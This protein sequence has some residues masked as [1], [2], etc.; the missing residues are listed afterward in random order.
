MD[1]KAEALAR[2]KKAIASLQRQMTERTLKLAAEVEVLMKHLTPSEARQFLQ[3]ACGLSVSD[4]SAYCKFSTT[5]K[6]SEEALRNARVQFSVVKALV[7]ADAETR[8][9]ALWKI[10]A[11]ARVDVRDVTAIKK[12][13]RDAKLP[14]EQVLAQFRMRRM[15]AAARRRASNSVAALDHRIAAFIRHVEG[16]RSQTARL[17]REEE[18]ATF[19]K[20]R[21]EARNLVP[22]FES[23]FGS[24]HRSVPELLNPS[25]DPEERR[26][27]FV[28]HAL[29]KFAAGK[30][31]RRGGYMLDRSRA[32]IRTT[33]I[34]E[35][36]RATT[37]APRSRTIRPWL[38]NQGQLSGVPERRLKFVELCAGAGGMALGLEAAGFDPIALI[39]MD[40]NAAATLRLNRP[41][42]NVIQQDLRT[43][44]FKPFRNPR[45]DLLVG[46][47]PCQPY[48]ED[49]KGLGK[50]DPR[51]LLLEGA[52][53][54]AELKPWSF[55]F[56]NVSGLLHA[57]HA[58]HLGRF[59]HTLRKSG[60][61]VDI[62]RM[63]TEDYGL[64]Q[65]RERLLIVGM[66]AESM[67]AFRM[68]PRFPHWRTNLG[69]AIGDLLAV[70]GWGGA[71]EWIRA[72][73]EQIVE[74]DGILL[75][76]VL[77]STIV[78]RKGGAREKEKLRWASKG[79]S[80]DGIADTAP[81]HEDAVAGGE[82][83]LPRLTS[84]M[85]AR[86][87]G[88]PDWWQYVG[89]KDSV[90]MQIGNAVPP[91]IA[92]AMGLAICAALEEVEFDYATTL[93]R[94]HHAE[95]VEPP[96]TAMEVPLLSPIEL[97]EEDRRAPVSIP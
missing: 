47:L 25:T 4:A 71:Q 50:D 54:V 18:A 55:L 24:S 36:L 45:V 7:S 44:D 59:L 56:E 2:A 26:I 52:R 82:G 91:V 61:V 27:G 93:L 9:E 76:G 28:H 60:Y 5:L 73:R 29:L 69:D 11:G 1:D 75:T 95:R 53:A 80:I 77:A 21:G 40:K 15:A 65:E 57:K 10:S 67:S 85:R 6:G 88:F 12:R 94:P 48:S 17:G 83:F 79:L 66:R 22:I 87:Q 19:E 62:L 32:G 68:P 8:Q 39:E 14:P 74:K 43:V 78:G 23:A 70:N 42:W 46:G 58:D 49:G 96:R 41:T 89:G 38:L 35:C 97:V 64:A 72:R 33:D 63:N 37:S 86:L 84:K 92:Q 90:A 3:S 31:G 34:V 81:T 51:D 20:I 13:L 30:F 16:F